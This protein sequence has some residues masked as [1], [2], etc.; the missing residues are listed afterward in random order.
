V[1]SNTPQQALTL[2]NDPTFVEAARML[3]QRVLKEGPS[4]SDE[5]RIDSIYRRALG[6]PAKP[7]EIE[8]LKRFLAAQRTHLKEDPAEAAKLLKVGFAPTAADIEPNELAAWTSLCR[9]VLNLHESITR[10]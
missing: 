8:S 5:Q 4:A 9:V 2:L 1:V 6:R 10:Y 7:K 3:A